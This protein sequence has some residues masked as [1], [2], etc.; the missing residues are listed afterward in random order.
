MFVKELSV[1]NY[2]TLEDVSLKFHDYYTAICGKNNVGKSN[3]L[4]AIR[5]LLSTGYFIRFISDEMFGYGEINYK[6]DFT[7]WKLKSGEDII[8][9]ILLEIDRDEDSSLYKFIRDLV[10]KDEDENEDNVKASL[11]IQYYKKPDNSS[12]YK[13]WFDDK[14]IEKE[15]SKREILRR[16]KTSEAILFHN[17]TENDSFS[18][19]RSEK[20]A[21]NNF[22]TETDNKNISEK[23]STVLKSV[24]KSLKKQ[25]DELGNLLGRLE[26]KYQV[27]FS[28]Q[29]LKLDREKIEISLKEKDVDVSLDEWGSGTK[30]RTLIFMS[31]L[32]ARKFQLNN[33]LSEK[34]YPI[35]LIEEPESFLHPSAQAEFGRILQDL[36]KE[37][38]I[39]VVV[40]THSPYLLSHKTPLA[41]ILVDRN[42]KAKNKEKGSIISIGQDENWYK[43][44]ALALGINGDDFG[45]LKNTIFNEANNVVLVEGAIDREYFELMKDEV[46]GTNALQKNVQV[47]DYGGADVL[48]NNAIISFVRNRFNNVVIT[49]DYDKYDEVKK[50]LS[51]IGFIEEKDLIPVG[52]NESG[53]KNIEGLLPLH[54]KNK[55]RELCPDLVD[56]AME[57]SKEKKE[58]QNKLKKKYFDEFKKSAAMA[59]GDYSEFYKLIKKINSNFK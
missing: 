52:K 25:Q 13:I 9:Q 14:E 48:K 44:F 19:F 7:K 5:N 56:I 50:Q 11:S 42:L 21:I 35:V 45:P 23:I 32:N 58:A 51:S 59:Q 36:A 54:V 12:D 3:I 2:R 40:T 30:N 57:N 17:S 47:Y 26:E 22:I 38:K 31:I 49:V 33:N 41:N 18:P 15:F 6:S 55:V 53:K 16:I 46:H 1:K 37:F 20:N 43:P 34:I 24:Q 8:I 27:S 4:R 10:L 39:Q 29:G 28:I